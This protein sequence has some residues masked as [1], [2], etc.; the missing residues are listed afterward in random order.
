M[1]RFIINTK[2]RGGNT[3]IIII[4]F[5]FIVIVIVNVFLIAILYFQIDISLRSIKLDI[6]SIVKNVALKNCD[7]DM[8]KNNVYYFN[9]DLMEED[10]NKV[11][12]KNNTDF[13][14][15]SIEYDQDSN[16]FKLNLKCCIK[17]IISIR[18]I[19]TYTIIV[20][21]KIKFKTM[22]VINISN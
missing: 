9:L 21:E 1:R 17:P 6:H 19:N 14:V 20:K 15:E 18:G 5:L 22:E 16:N 12:E 11:L 8:L 4:I 3:F 2:Y 10:I 13:K 7:S